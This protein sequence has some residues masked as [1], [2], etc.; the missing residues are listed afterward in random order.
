MVNLSVADL[1]VTIICMPVAVSQAKSIVWSHGEVMCKLSSYLQGKYFQPVKKLPEIDHPL[2]RATYDH[3][4]R[5]SLRRHTIARILSIFIA[6]FLRSKKRKIITVL[7][8]FYHCLLQLCLISVCSNVTLS[9]FV[10]YFFMRI[11][12]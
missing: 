9:Y 4:L 11:C 6:P 5:V 3:A 10:K 8:I 1:L 7:A 2:I 12:K